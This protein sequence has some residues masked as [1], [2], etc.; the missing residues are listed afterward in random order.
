MFCLCDSFLMS[1]IAMAMLQYIFL[2]L[3]PLLPANG[4]YYSL[5]SCYNTVRA[6]E[7]FFNGFI[8][9]GLSSSRTIHSFRSSGRGK[10]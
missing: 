6:Y 5:P 4:L 2:V 10:L 3:L 8:F 7:D 1:Y 9:P